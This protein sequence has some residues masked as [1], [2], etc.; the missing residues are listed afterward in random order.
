MPRRRKISA[1]KLL[2]LCL[3]SLA[4]LSL[5]SVVVLVLA[6]RGEH[7]Q[8]VLGLL[9]VVATVSGGLLAALTPRAQLPADDVPEDGAGP[10][11]GL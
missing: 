11:D 7:E 5:I 2:T 1:F 8:I 6:G 3:T 9:G 10:T 4:V